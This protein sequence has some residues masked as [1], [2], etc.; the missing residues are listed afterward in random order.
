MVNLSKSTIDFY[1]PYLSIYNPT[2]FLNAV[3]HFGYLITLLN[4]SVLL[5][6]LDS[7]LHNISVM[8]VENK[9]SHT[10]KWD[11]LHI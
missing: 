5:H 3:Q 6:A 11:K 10:T 1:Q 7:K 2:L 8:S 9:L 4:M